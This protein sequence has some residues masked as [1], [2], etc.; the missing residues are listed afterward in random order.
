MILVMN[1]HQRSI[2]KKYFGDMFTEKQANEAVKRE[3]PTELTQEELNYLVEDYENIEIQYSTSKRC[4]K[5]LKEVLDFFS[6]SNKT[7][8]GIVGEHGKISE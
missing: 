2:W 6:E 5:E 8:L 7:G 3:D 4:S 1:K